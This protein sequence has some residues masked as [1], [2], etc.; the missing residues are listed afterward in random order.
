MLV[1]DYVRPAAIAAG[2][3][4]EDCP[5]FG[6]HNLRHSLCTF[7]IES[8]HDPVAV[9]RLLRHSDV[10]MTMQYAHLDSMRRKMQGEFVEKFTGVSPGVVQ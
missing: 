8:E 10:K 5:R 2:V 1:E 6:F 4:P 3:I 7:L 9:Q